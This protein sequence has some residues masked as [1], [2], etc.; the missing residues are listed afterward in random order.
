[1]RQLGACMKKLTLLNW[2]LGISAVILIA[3]QSM[4]D[5]GN[6]SNRMQVF[7]VRGKAGFH[8]LFHSG[9]TGI[10]IFAAMGTPL[11][12]VTGGTVRFA[13]E[14]K[15]GKAAYLTTADGSQYY[16]NHMSK[17]GPQKNGQKVKAGEIIGYVGD[18]GNA[19]GKDPHVHFEY[20]PQGAVKIDPYAE[21][22]R[23][24]R[25]ENKAA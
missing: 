10:D 20:R 12:A 15:G 25:E 13:N 2:I 9:H 7:P 5:E 8:S 18:S 16:Y 23:V 22:K 21:L 17:F 19:K 3:R 11:A 6:G 14:P 4:K 24:Q 1:M